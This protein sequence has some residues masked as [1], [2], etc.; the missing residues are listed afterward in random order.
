MYAEAVRVMARS[1]RRAEARVASDASKDSAP[2][3]PF[4]VLMTQAGL[5]GL[6]TKTEY[7]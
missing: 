5:G 6:E 7:H 2:A 1:V 3:R 4:L